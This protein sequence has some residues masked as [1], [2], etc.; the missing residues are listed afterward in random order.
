MVMA[1]V[2]MALAVRMMMNIMILMVLMRM[3]SVTTTKNKIMM[4]L[5][6]YDANCCE[7]IRICSG[8]GPE[9]S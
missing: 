2:M 1:R 7:H 5:R 3:R 4:F 6:C 8:F 9:G